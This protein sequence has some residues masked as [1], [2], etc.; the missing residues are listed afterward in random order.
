[1]KKAWFRPSAVLMS[2]A[3]IALA[4]CARARSGDV[5]DGGGGSDAIAITLHD[6]EFAPDVLRLEAGTNV[7]VEV[8]NEGGND[9]NFTIDDL[10]LSTGTVEPGSVVTAM[11]TVPN[12]G[13]GY[14][15]TFHPSM[16]GEI[17]PT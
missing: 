1:M 11:F 2:L 7:S 6:D 14:H 16:S 15:C 17:V 13:T 10:D 4:G 5:H 9:H 12:G 3:L 8:R